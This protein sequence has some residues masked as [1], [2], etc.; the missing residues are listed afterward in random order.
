MATLDSGSTHGER[1]GEDRGGHG[2]AK[3][4]AREVKKASE[5]GELE[6]YG[7]GRGG[8]W[9]K[10]RARRGREAKWWSG[11]F[12]HYR[13]CKREKREVLPKW[14]CVERRCLATLCRFSREVE[15]KSVAK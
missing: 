13:R 11:F 2:K 1:H 8:R 10:A 9:R 15:W 3:R 5:E 12:A 4:G 6:R 7:E 14:S